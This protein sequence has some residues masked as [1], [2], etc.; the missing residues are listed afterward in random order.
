MTYLAAACALPLGIFLL[1]WI[2]QFRRQTWWFLAPVGVVLGAGLGVVAPPDL[3]DPQVWDYPWG[4]VKVDSFFLGPART[5]VLATKLSESAHWIPLTM[6]AAVGLGGLGALTSAALAIRPNQPL[7][8]L[9]C[10]QAVTLGCAL[11]V[12]LFVS[13]FV[14]DR[15]LLAWTVPLP[16]LW[17]AL[18]PRWAWIVQMVVLFGFM[19]LHVSALW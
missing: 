11:L 18:L 16:V 19:V 17:L 6:M 4:Q 10:I 8:I 5:L 1:T 12:Y 13:A 9:A 3:I 2:W 7:A 15:F 14:F